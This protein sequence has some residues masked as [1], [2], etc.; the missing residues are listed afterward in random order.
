MIYDCDVCRKPIGKGEGVLHGENRLD[1]AAGFSFWRWN[2]DAIRESER[3][4]C[5][6]GKVHKRCIGAQ[7]QE[8]LTRFD[9]GHLILRG[10]HIVITRKKM[11]NRRANAKVS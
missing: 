11:E 9:M 1:L 6:L 7:V 3:Y 5:P 2:V 8:Y 4:H 10:K